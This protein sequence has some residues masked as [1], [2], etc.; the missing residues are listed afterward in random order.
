MRE[1]A[2]RFK[3]HEHVTRGHSQTRHIDRSVNSAQFPLFN[4]VT[5]GNRLLKSPCGPRCAFYSEKGRLRH[6][7]PKT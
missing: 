3:S 4:S 5:P 1:V 7:V 2:Q 6:V